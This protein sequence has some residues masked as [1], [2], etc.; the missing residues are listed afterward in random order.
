[1]ERDG[2]CVALNETI[3]YED[4]ICNFKKVQHY[5]SKKKLQQSIIY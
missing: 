1:M 4:F 2:R 5:T 3:I